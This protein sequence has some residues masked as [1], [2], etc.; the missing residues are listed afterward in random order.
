VHVRVGDP[1]ARMKVPKRL[2]LDDDLGS[3]AIAIGLGIED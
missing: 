1:L 2:A 3:F